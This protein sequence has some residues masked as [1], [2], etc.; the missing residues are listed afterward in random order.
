MEKYQE[1]LEKAHYYIKACEH[2]L[3][4]TYPAINEPKILLTCLDHLFLCMTNTVGAIL[5]F[6]RKKRTIPPF[7][8]TFES[9]FNMFQLK[10]VPMHKIPKKDVTFIDKLQ[11]LITFHKQAPV[12]FTR[13]NQ[14]I[15]C[16]TEYGVEKINAPRIREF[17]LDAK[18]VLKKMEQIIHHDV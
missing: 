14:Y 6:E 5:H 12:E 10:I 4:V 1:C 7:H 11:Q 3:T 13:D 18:Q 16:D 2:M 17:I 8:T 9:K 15:M